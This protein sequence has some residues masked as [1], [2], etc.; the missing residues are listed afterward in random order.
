MP[1]IAT[2]SISISIMIMKNI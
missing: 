1:Y 2:L